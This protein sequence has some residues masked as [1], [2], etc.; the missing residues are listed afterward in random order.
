MSITPKDIIEDLEKYVDLFNLKLSKEAKKTLEEVEEFA[1][2][3]NYPCNYI[4]FFSK[5]IRNVKEL[6]RLFYSKGLNPNLSALILEIK[7]YD[8]IETTTNF[9]KGSKL[10]SYIHDRSVHDKT[11]ILDKAMQ[12]CVKEGREEIENKDILFSAMD[13]FEKNLL[14]NSNKEAQSII[15]TDKLTLNN[16]Y[17]E[18]DDNLEIS[19][20]EIRAG[21]KKTHLVICNS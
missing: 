7:F 10:Y 17:G 12:Y 21:F 6:Q 4:L 13:Y 8:L 2:K 14:K 18:F 15:H 19:L 3:C 20:D 9:Q 16:I 1:Y 11:F 5:T